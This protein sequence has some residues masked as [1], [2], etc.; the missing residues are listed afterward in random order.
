MAPIKSRSE[1]P[2]TEFDEAKT[3]DLYTPD[4]NIPDTAGADAPGSSPTNDRKRPRAASGVVTSFKRP[5]ITNSRRNANQ[6]RSQPK[7]Q[8]KRQP[9]AKT[10][11]IIMGTDIGTT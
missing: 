10:P 1:S 11:T 3:Y 7:R 5:C 8:P 4:A 9:R 2:L 6:S